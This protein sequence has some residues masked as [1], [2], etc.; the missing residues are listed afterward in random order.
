VEELLLH[1]VVDG[2]A[3]RALAERLHRDSRGNPFFLAQMLRA[4]VAQGVIVAGPGTQRG[5]VALEPDEIARAALP[6]PGTIRQ[7][8]L[9]RL[10][11]LG[12]DARSV[13]DLLAVAR[14]P[15]ND[16]VIAAASDTLSTQRLQQALDEAVSAGLLSASDAGPGRY[17]LARHR[18]ADV[19]VEE[20]SA[21]HRRDLHGRLARALERCH[22]D[23]LDAVLSAVARHYAEAG[24]AAV[25]WP[26]LLDAARLLLRRGDVSDALDRLDQGLL[27]EPR[28]RGYAT[29]ADADRRLS[30]ALQL[31]ASA[32]V[33]LG[34]WEEARAEARR[35]L[36][37]AQI[38]HDDL[39][40]SRAATELGALERRCHQMDKAE[41][42]LDLA[43]RHARASGDRGAAILP[44]YERGGL[45]WARGDLEAAQHEWVE[46]LTQAEAQSD[47]RM[48]A[49]GANGLGVLA[50]CRG[51]AAEGRRQFE[52]AVELCERHGMAE[53]LVISRINL[54]ELHHMTG[55]LRKGCELADHTVAQ[56]REVGNAYGLALGLRYR[57]LLLPDVGRLAD[58]RENAAEAARMQA[59]LGNPE[60]ELSAHVMAVRT[61]LYCN[62]LDAAEVSLAACLPLLL[63]HDTEGYSPI[64]HAWRARVFIARGNRDAALAALDAAQAAPGRQWPHQAIRVLLNVARAYEGLGDNQR[65]TSLAEQALRLSDASGYRLYAM[66]ARH[67]AA[68]TSAEE[69]VRARHQR[70][71]QALARSLAA[72][73][74]HEDAAG[75]MARQPPLGA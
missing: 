49:L 15:L 72:N 25:A 44:I 42:W 58:A 14:E 4:L 65:A 33:H 37:I 19:L 7:A 22:R 18:L 16:A 46:V 71:G 10:A 45:H 40:I 23:D 47:E 63:Q 51:D 36:D 43:I 1:L 73:L 28:A 56:A 11:S 57:A 5:S 39:R 54:I 55:N 8:L 61:A 70:V 53:R 52:R 3:A 2:P 24:Y 38:L 50:I 29:L 35:A 62:D 27:I 32:L 13:L 34:R 41:D 12:L 64:V 60:E 30:E 75:F 59:A 20:L 66:R 31:R 6:V 74:P 69:N 67:I 17:T 68:R 9:A 48:Q 21:D 26:Y